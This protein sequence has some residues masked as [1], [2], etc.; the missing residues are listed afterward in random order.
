MNESNISPGRIL[1]VDDEANIRSGLRAVLTRA[2]HEVQDVDSVAAALSLLPSFACETAIVDV[3]MP[4]GSGIEL[5]RQIRQ[6]WPHISVIMLTGQGTLESAMT[7]V[8]EGAF[9]YLLKPAQPA[10][11]RRVANLAITTARRRREHER[12]VQTLQAGLQ[13]LETL[14]PLSE[15]L[16]AQTAVSPRFLRVSQ[17]VIDTQAY[18]VACGDNPVPLT[19]TEYKLL[20]TLAAQLGIA[21]SYTDLARQVLDYEAE[22]WEAKELV[23]RHVFSLR[24]KIEDDPS[25]PQ[26]LLNVRGVGYRL[27]VP[28]GP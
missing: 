7:A 6:Q 23:K 28:P 26:M 10:E 16:V 20:V 2:G 27:I 4:G 9:D 13:R 8:R 22:P 1:I 25:L 15:T 14:P 21:I 3:R 11:I 19:P 18:T 5:L 17:L 12:L 24:Q